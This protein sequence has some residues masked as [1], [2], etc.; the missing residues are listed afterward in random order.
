MANKGFYVKGLSALT[1]Q[2]HELP[3]KIEKN[4]LRGGLRAAAK[5]IADEAKRRAPVRTG[6]LRKSIRV[7]TGFDRKHGRVTATVRAGDD[8]A[9]YAH[10]V[11]FGTDRHIIAGEGVALGRRGRALGIAAINRRAKRGLRI[12]GTF[13]AT[14]NH[15]GSKERPFMRPAL[16]HAAGEAVDVMAGYIRA[17]LGQVVK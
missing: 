7:A 1:Q 2:L 12:N 14:A 8:K 9:F 5:V 3:A 13:V 10:W 16:D 17:R 15:P 4:I 11:E 6:A